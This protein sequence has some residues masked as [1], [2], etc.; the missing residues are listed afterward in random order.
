MGNVIQTNVSSLNAQ[1]ALTSSNNDLRTSFQRLSSGLRINS[2]A[3]DAAGLQISNRLTSQIGGLGQAV[4]NSNDGISLAQTA[5]GALQEA[6]NILQRIRDLSIQ[7]SNGSNSAQDRAALQ[8][9]VGQLQTELNRIAETTAFGGRNLLNGTFGSQLFQV[10]S[11]ANETVAVSIG[12]AKATSIGRNSHDLDGSIFGD[13]LAAANTIP[14]SNGLAAAASFAVIG[15]LGA[16]TL[17]VAANDT[18]ENVALTVNQNSAT[19]GVS[20]DARNVI[21]LS[22]FGTGSVSFNLTGDNTAAESFAASIT[23]T[24][25]LSAMA[26]AINEK[27][28]VTGITA[29]AD[30]SGNLTLISETGDDI[31]IGDYT[32]SNTTNTTVTVRSRNFANTGNAAGSADVTLT[33][34]GTDSTLATGIVRIDGGRSGFTF[35]GASTEFS[36]TA[37]GGS[38]VSSVASIDIATAE[39]AQDALGVIDGAIASIDSFRSSLGAVQNRLSA[40]IANLQNISENVSAARSAIRDAD[41]AHETSELAKNQVLQQAGTSILSQANASSQSILSLL[42]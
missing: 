22:G 11:E 2:A 14:A 21:R 15:N 17:A 6:T 12:S 28:G 3:D 20:A 8:Q 27:S 19:T 13:A 25:D 29:S 23:D 37:L 4:R 16:A 34:G 38:A 24:N 26:D 33:S 5:E 7:S 1:R 9:E 42:Q 10:G 30:D 39:G 18:A 36:A 35:S 31:G 32:T 41:F 40:T